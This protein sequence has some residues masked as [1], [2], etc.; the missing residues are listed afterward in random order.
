MFA[1]PQGGPNEMFVYKTHEH[2]S[3]IYYIAAN[4]LGGKLEKTQL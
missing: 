3:F 2:D 4:K 1:F